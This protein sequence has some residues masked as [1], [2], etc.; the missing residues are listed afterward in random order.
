MNSQLI[1]AATAVIFAGA[2]MAGDVVGRVYDVGVSDAGRNGI[3]AVSVTIKD[4]NE[5]V[6]GNGITDGKGNYTVAIQVPA[7]MKLRAYYE[8]IGYFSYPTIRDVVLSVPVRVPL[9]RGNASSEYYKVV[10]E[11]MGSKTEDP[12]EA[13]QVIAAVAALPKSDIAKILDQLKVEA[14]TPVQTQF[15]AAERTTKTLSSVLESMK[16]KR[17]W[18][19]VKAYANVPSP[20]S[21]WLYGTVENAAQKQAVEGF[22]KSLDK[23]SLTVK[24]DV[25]VRAAN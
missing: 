6:V 22:T 11:S 1:L 23:G 25:I 17:E 19:G 13:A 3:P 15:A 9:A 21:I 10:V 2:A 14:P 18:A 12:S 8:K 24:N 4:A 5:Q 20:G 7:R 16:G